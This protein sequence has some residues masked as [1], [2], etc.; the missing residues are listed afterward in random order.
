MAC[1]PGSLR[2][3]RG[4]ASRRRGRCLADTERMISA[5]GVPAEKRGSC[6]GDRRGQDRLDLRTRQ[7]VRRRQPNEACLVAGAERNLLRIGQPRS[8]E[9]YRLRPLAPAASETMQ[10][11][12][13][14]VGPYPNTKKL[15]VVRE[16]K[17]RG[18]APAHGFPRGAD[19]RPITRLEL[20]DESLELPIRGRRCGRSLGTGVH[21]GLRSLCEIYC[22][23]S[24]HETPKRSLTQPNFLLNP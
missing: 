2:F 19:Q 16:F 11:E 5:P 14:T 24:C 17:G 4:Q 22:R 20:V 6:L 15:V 3:E 13:R 12:G 18:Q 23:L 8:L 10:S 7:I 9:K 1:P 21:D